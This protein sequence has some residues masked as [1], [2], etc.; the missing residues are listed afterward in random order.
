[1]TFIKRRLEG[2]Y[3]VCYNAFVDHRGFLTRTYDIDLFESV[4]ITAQWI[5]H[6]LSYTERRNTLR[7]LHAQETAFSEAKLL[8]PLSGQM[9]W[10]SVDLRKES[11]TFSQW[12][13]TLLDPEKN[14]AL[15]VPRGFGHG[16]LSI[17]D[18]VL[19]HIFAD[20]RYAPAHG[21]GIRWDDP[22]LAVA[23]PE[24]DAPRILSDEHADN[25]DF[26]HFL[27]TVGGL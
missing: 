16:C 20:N 23:W 3:D 21:I 4:G 27:A 6:S 14:Q 25:P 12:D 19:L 11:P 13:S 22:Q 7:G 5:Q 1:M 18:K 2:M 24:L 15:Y 9:F 17:T 26:R 8:V 10:V